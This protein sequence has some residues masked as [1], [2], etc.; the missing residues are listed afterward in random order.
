MIANGAFCES[1][2]S[3]TNLLHYKLIS[4]V[5]FEC[6][7]NMLRLLFVGLLLINNTSAGLRYSRL[8]FDN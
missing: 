7:R 1:V 2:H 4:N 5:L 6:Y 3:V 8:L